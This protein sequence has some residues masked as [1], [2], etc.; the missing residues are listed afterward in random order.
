MMT[1]EF[2]CR[3]RKGGINVSKVLTVSHFL[4]KSRNLTLKRILL[5]AVI[6]E[7][8]LLKY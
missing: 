4:S 3:L 6:W 8:I 2:I 1:I 7:K 5:N